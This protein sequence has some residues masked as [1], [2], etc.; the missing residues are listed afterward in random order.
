MKSLLLI[1]ILLTLFAATFSQEP[2]RWR[3]LILDESR[4]EQAIAKL[5]QPSKPGIIIKGT[6][7]AA[8]KRGA[9]VQAFNWD[10]VEGFRDVNLFFIDGNLAVIY[11]E[12]PMTPIPTASFVDAYPGLK[13]YAVTHG[14]LL[15]LSKMTMNSFE[16]VT[17]KGKISGM[18]GGGMIRSIGAF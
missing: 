3:D 18:T 5:G 14:S 16:A 10:D 17:P 8:R 11:L 12:R 4:P 7:K 15:G 9:N 2:H 13:F 1:I 6:L